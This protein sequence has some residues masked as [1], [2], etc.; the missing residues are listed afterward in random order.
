MAIRNHAWYAANSVRRY[1][2]DETALCI[3]DDGAELPNNIIV[4]VALTAP[5]SI[6]TSLFIGGITITDTLVTAIILSSNVLPLAEGSQPTEETQPVA[7]ISILKSDLSL[8]RNYVVTPLTD[9]VGGWIVFGEGSQRNFVGRFGSAYQTAIYPRCISLYDDLPVKSLRK[10]TGQ[11]ELTGVVNLAA[12]N[13]ITIRSDTVLV[14]GLLRTIG[15]I[16]LNKVA[17]DENV[18][19]KYIGPCGKRPESRSCDRS[20]IQFL[21]GARPDC[22]GNIDVTFEFATVYPF[23]ENKG[24]LAV[25]IPTGLADI[26]AGVTRLPDT[27]GNLPGVGQGGV[28]FPPEVSLPSLPSVEVSVQ[29]DSL[30]CLVFPVYENFALGYDT[31][32]FMTMHG[33]FVIRDYDDAPLIVEPSRTMPPENDGYAYPSDVVVGS[34]ISNDVGQRNVAV[35]PDCNILQGNYRVAT[36]TRVTSYLGRYNTGL[37]LNYNPANDY[38]VHVMLDLAS[39]AITYRL[40]APGGCSTPQTA[41]TIDYPASLVGIDDPAF[42]HIWYRIEALFLEDE[43][44]KPIIRVKRLTEAVPDLDVSVEI[45][46]TPWAA[47]VPNGWYGF[48]SDRCVAYF[49]NFW[50][51][52]L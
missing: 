15:I 21:G 44:L 37:I 2:I 19:E 51:E 10:V 49:A 35:F 18:F 16:E 5:K 28:F 47:F 31:N 33:D 13:D 34:A 43:P 46:L 40:C 7:A 11:D 24:G 45:D 36:D 32:R 26:C 12:G 25:S 23:P 3:A 42:V 22:S 6:G 1:P 4:D 41:T 8:Y 39:Q 38:Y 17:T 30:S 48:G 14:D 27:E 50:M 20:A 9:G 52:K 29:S